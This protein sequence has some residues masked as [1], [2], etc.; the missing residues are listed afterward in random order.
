MEGKLSNANFVER[1]D[2]EVVENE[3]T[4]L[5]EMKNELELLERNLGGLG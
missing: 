1:A 3:R 5:V 2:P 4:R